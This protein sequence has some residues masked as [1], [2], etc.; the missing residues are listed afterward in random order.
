MTGCMTRLNLCNLSPRC[1]RPDY[2][3]YLPIERPIEGAEIV[4]GAAVRAAAEGSL[5]GA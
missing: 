2:Y 4:A 3:C 5:A 1:R